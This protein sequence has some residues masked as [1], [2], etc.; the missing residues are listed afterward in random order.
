MLFWWKLLGPIGNCF[1]ENVII[2]DFEDCIGKTGQRMKKEHYRLMDEIC[3][4]TWGT[5]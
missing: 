1:S 5:K 2:E 4:K 3:A